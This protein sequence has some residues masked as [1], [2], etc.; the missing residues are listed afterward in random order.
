MSKTKIYPV[1]Y[2][3]IGHSYLKHGPFEGWQT[4]GFWG[5]AASEP[6]K[7]YFHQVQH[8][9]QA[10]LACSVQA[11]AEN[12]ATYERLCTQ[13]AT[14][15]K[16]VNSSEY[17]QMRQQLI[18]FRPNLISVYIGGGNTIANDPVSL[19]QFYEVLYDLINTYKPAEAVV[20][21]PYSNRVSTVCIDVA[22]KYG[23]IPVD[24][25]FI[26]DKGKTAE[27]PYYALAQYPD[28]DEA[29]KAGAIEFRTH[30]GDFGHETIARHIA[31]AALPQLMENI[32]PVEVCLPLQL[33]ID[34]PQ[35][36]SGSE[37]CVQLQVSP[38]PIDADTGVIWSVDDPHLAQI[39][40]N[41]MLTAIN[42]GTV[43]V[44]AKSAVDP[45]VSTS[46]QIRIT[47]Q[48][49]WCTLRYL[50]GTEE[51][52]SRIPEDAAYLKGTYS[53]EAAGAAYLPM[54]T[55]YQFIG[56]SDETAPGVIVQELQMDRDRTVCANWRLAECWDFDTMYDSAGVRMGGFNVRYE[57]GIVRASSAPGTGVAVYHESLRLPA[58]DYRS[59]CVRI[60]IDTEQPEE[61]VLLKVLTTEEELSCLVH[62]PSQTMEDHMLDISKLQGIITGFRIEPQMPECCIHVDRVAFEK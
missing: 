41:G 51:P 31:E 37:E 27:N 49:P 33:T 34:A 53:L 23:F 46:V 30:P 57:K 60:R 61:G 18:D 52:V 24:L 39:D 7:D 5:M 16:Y 2:Y 38:Q 8:H 3:A 59:F 43:T 55:G 40:R 35:V 42:N 29:A 13:D 36:I 58:R 45:G 15:E 48:T 47:G 9:L 6:D 62:M 19:T 10:Q 32:S 44:T 21:C 54:R 14:V 50:P 11:I 26:H 25:R 17:A 28:Y 1:R 22:R 12:Y 56:W 4:S 20:I